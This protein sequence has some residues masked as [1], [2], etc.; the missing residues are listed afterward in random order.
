MQCTTVSLQ[1]VMFC[2][3]VAL[4]CDILYCRI[5]SHCDVL[6]CSGPTERVPADRAGDVHVT[7]E[8][9]QGETTAGAH[10]DCH[11]HPSVQQGVWQGWGRH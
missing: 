9:R 8:A 3:A 10:N 2:V 1:T 6:C 5:T 11:G 4:Q 7:V